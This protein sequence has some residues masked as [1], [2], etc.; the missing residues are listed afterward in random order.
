MSLLLRSFFKVLKVLAQQDDRFLIGSFLKDFYWMILIII[1]I[2]N[3]EKL[4]IFIINF[5]LS[6]N[7]LIYVYNY[8]NYI[9]NF[10]Y[11]F[12]KL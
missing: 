4:I 9:L 2:A 12:N 1:N 10:F 7:N 11:K 6:L 5:N 8:K 3:F